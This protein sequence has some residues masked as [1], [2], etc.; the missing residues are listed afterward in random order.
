M[1]GRVV[2]IACSLALFAVTLI[3]AATASGSVSAA[4][5]PV[6]G[7]PVA[8]PA[9][10]VA[11]KA[12]SVAFKVTRSGSSAALTS[13]RMALDPTIDGRVIPHT[14][15][16]RGGTARARLVVPGTAGGKQL[17]LKLT[18]RA[19]GQ[20]TTKVSSFR[21][22]AAALPA[23][24]VGDASGP[25][26]NSGTTTLSFPVTLSAA[27]TKAVTVHYATSDGTATA[28]SDYTAAHG[29]LTFQPGEKSKSIAVSV[30]G[31][32]T[33][34]PDESLSLMLSDAANAGIAGATA[35]GTITNDDTAV[36]VTAG[37]YKGATQEGNFVFFTVLPDRTV[38]GFRANDISEN[39]DLGGTLSGSVSWGTSSFPVAADGGL[40]AEGQWSGSQKQ[41]DIEFTAQ[42]WQVTGK[43][44]SANA[45]SG[46]IALADELNYQGAHY[47]CSST[48]TW[49]ATLQ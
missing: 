21:V 42:S 38:T 23:L 46:T 40:T 10:P 36:P 7:K 43:F 3:A 12:F 35:T 27:A 24:S 41:G 6:I 29:T 5:K 49:S 34:E 17:K 14:E 33:I 19:G 32:L 15:S 20:S 45:I 30:V 37:Q 28:P 16:F 11:G 1:A 18:V 13:G 47:R 4:G 2:T 26:G 9:Q 31:D 48:V 8:V 39:C 25:E 22:R 44:T